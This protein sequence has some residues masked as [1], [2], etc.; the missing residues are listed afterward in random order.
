VRSPY[1]I[2]RNPFGP[3]FIGGGSSSGSAVAVAAGAGRL[4]PRHRHGGLGP[5]PGKL[6]QHRRAEAHLTGEALNPRLVALGARFRGATKTAPV[7]RCFALPDGRRPGPVRVGEGGGAIELEI[8]DVPSE[9]IGAL[10]ASI[11]PPL[12]LGTIELADG[13]M[14]TGVICE[15]HAVA[16]ATDITRY[17][18]WRAWRRACE[19]APERLPTP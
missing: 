7:Y 13:A 6:Q 15:G 12:G 2:P 17:G 19:T 16:G 8:W 10:L 9:S 14:V 18:G 4:R 11:A 1:G 5:H 3:A